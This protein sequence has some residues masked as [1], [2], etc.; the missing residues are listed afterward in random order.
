MTKPSDPILAELERLDGLR[1]K[2][3]TAS[4]SEHS[5]LGLH[6]RAQLDRAYPLLSRALRAALEA[7]DDWENA[8]PEEAPGPD[9]VATPA[10]LVLT[11]VR[12]DLDPNAIPCP[13]CNR[14]I[15]SAGEGTWTCPHCGVVERVEVTT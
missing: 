7:L 2:V 5:H 8:L 4:R 13:N 11:R 3:A 14:K 10:D 9:A 1:E 12:A 6:F 15:P